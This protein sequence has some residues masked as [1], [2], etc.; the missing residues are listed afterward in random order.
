MAHIK[1]QGTTYTITFGGIEAVN[2][3]EISGTLRDIAGRQGRSYRGFAFHPDTPRSRAAEPI[4]IWT[5]R[6][7]C[8]AFAETD[9][10]RT[11]VRGHLGAVGSG[12]QGLIVSAFSAHA[13]A[14]V[15]RTDVTAIVKNVSSGN[16]CLKLLTPGLRKSVNIALV[17]PQPGRFVADQIVRIKGGTFN[18]AELTDDD[19]VGHALTCL[20][21]DIMIIQNASENIDG[22]RE[23][24]AMEIDGRT[25]PNHARFVGDVWS[26]RK[27]MAVA[28]G[29]HQ[30]E[31]ADR[32]HHV[33]L[34]MQ[35]DHVATARNRSAG[36]RLFQG[37]LGHEF[38]HI[39][40]AAIQFNP[41]LIPGPSQLWDGT[42][43]INEL[44]IGGLAHHPAFSDYHHGGFA[45]QYGP[46]TEIFVPGFA[47]TIAEGTPVV[48]RLKAVFTQDGEM[49]WR[50]IDGRVDELDL[51]GLPNLV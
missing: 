18:L 48:A 35:P 8:F 22:I 47:P 39:P 36:P 13:G 23:M 17:T 33:E 40:A 43:T 42:G 25:V 7:D 2:D 3:L 45:I 10:R 31:E 51:S 28:L 19:E 1:K 12:R 20:P 26:S 14:P 44:V 30:W 29:L 49:F 34:T 5:P 21:K 41:I 50:S 11:L 9:A 6:A 27:E 24:P 15:Q 4:E 16:L 32:F 38:D 46:S 37:S